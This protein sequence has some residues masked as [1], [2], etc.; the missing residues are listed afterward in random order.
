M[1]TELITA[2]YDAAL[3]DIA[4]IYN[5]TRKTLAE[6]YWQIGQRIVQVEQDGDLRAAYGQK[7][8]DRLSADLL[9]RYNLGFSVANL[10]RMR[11]FYLS[12]P[13]SSAPRE[14]TWT[15]YVELLGVTDEKARKRLEKL[16]ARD[17]L[18]TRELRRLVKEEDT[19]GQALEAGPLARP[20]DLR[21]HTYKEADVVG[22]E[23]PEGS[24][25]ID[26]GFG[27]QVVLSEE[28]LKVVTVTQ[29]PA[30]VY[31]A[32]VDRVVDGDTL[33]VEVDLGFGVCVKERLRLRGVD[34]PEL[35]TSEGVRAREFV[36][37]LLPRGTK[38]LIRSYKTDI[39][40]RFVV[41]LLHPGGDGGLFLN[42]ELLDRG[43]AVRMK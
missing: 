35:K 12:H 37:T 29:R 14:L 16:A 32:F 15:H 34:A 13:K 33:L 4:G 8:L 39:Y 41:D 40:G 38:V 3:E 27:V 36:W 2:R 21:L 23:V 17:G 24:R 7:L 9:K 11:K 5:E 30:Y 10:E 31:E 42:Q 28:A 19:G 18:S 20:T 22:A 43:L 1:S 25:P 26:L 6:A